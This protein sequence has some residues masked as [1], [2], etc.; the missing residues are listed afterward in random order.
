MKSIGKVKQTFSYSPPT[1][2]S[3]QQANMTI[4]SQETVSYN[5]PSTGLFAVIPHSWVPFAE[6]MRLDRP[7][8]YYAFYWHYA[9]GLS[10]AACVTPPE[11]PNPSV[12][13]SL[14]GYLAVWV[15][16][17]RGAVCTVND[18]LD[19]DFDRQVERT[20]FR[21]LARRAVSTSQ[22]TIFTVIQ[23]VVLH[24][25]LT[26]L[27]SASRIYGDLTTFILCVYALG[28]RVTHFPQVILGLGFAVAIF[29]C[30]AALHVDPLSW[31]LHPEDGI[32]STSPDSSSILI[33]TTSLY[34]VSVIWTIIYDTIY[35]HQDRKDDIK[36][37]VRSLA[38]LLGDKTKLFLSLLAIMQVMLL[39]TVGAKCGFSVTYYMVCCGGT[40]LSLG[41][42][43][44]KVDLRQPESCAWWFGPGS[45][46]VG[47]S[48]VGGF[49]SEYMHR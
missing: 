14:A 28:K 4:K 48:I 34:F 15:L 44:Y 23:L 12:L 27:P 36:A 31:R 38:V 25:L 29:L 41:A 7:Q 39:I 33:A 24:I 40:A 9:I 2:Y 20:R 30:C 32:S 5:P 19:Q 3:I 16:V 46:L 21:P 6:L 8:G 11:P 1:I 43:L 45:R 10:F 47:C 37:G 49:L 18:I 35:A 42:M 26:P 22:A 13:L 17:H